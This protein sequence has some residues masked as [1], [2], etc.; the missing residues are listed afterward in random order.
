MSKGNKREYEQNKKGCA[1]SA[2]VPEDK[3]TEERPTIR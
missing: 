1:V 3:A 2:S